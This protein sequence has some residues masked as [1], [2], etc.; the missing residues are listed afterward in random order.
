MLDYY[1][2]SIELYTEFSQLYRSE[3]ALPDS[4][5]KCKPAGLNKEKLNNLRSSKLLFISFVR[6]R[7][8]RITNDQ[9]CEVS[10]SGYLWRE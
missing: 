5:D 7:E 6:V 3:D 8:F 9:F 1:R 10:L 4:Y 2:K